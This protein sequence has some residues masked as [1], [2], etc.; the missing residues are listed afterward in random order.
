MKNFI[1]IVGLVFLCLFFAVGCVTTPC[2]PQIIETPVAIP[3]PQP[4]VINKVAPPVVTFVDP[5]NEK[6]IACIDETNAKAM[7]ET[8]KGLQEENAELRKALQNYSSQTP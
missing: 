8:I 1:K 4:P 5:L 7:I 6:A 3:C 2:K